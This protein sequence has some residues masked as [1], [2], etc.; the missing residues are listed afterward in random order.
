MPNEENQ[1]SESETEL[2]KQGDSKPDADLAE[3]QRK[4]AEELG[5]GLSRVLPRPS[6]S[7][8]KTETLASTVEKI[9]SEYDQIKAR[10]LSIS[11]ITSAIGDLLTPKPN[12]EKLEDSETGSMEKSET[13]S[14]DE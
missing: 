10:K 12:T 2:S 4:R 3:K 9:Q 13:K 7:S 6:S 8:H 14:T 11:G 1:S 5:S